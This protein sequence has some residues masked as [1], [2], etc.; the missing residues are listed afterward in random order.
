MLKIPELY[1]QI[2]VQT[3]STNFH[4]NPSGV[5]RVFTYGGTDRQTDRHEETKSRF[6][7][8]RNVPKSEK[9]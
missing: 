5:S 8:V 2:L 7:E 4:E 1:R 9:V 3:H 6:M